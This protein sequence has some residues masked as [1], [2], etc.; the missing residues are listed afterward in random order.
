VAVRG[1]QAARDS[2]QE[3]CDGHKNRIGWKHTTQSR[4]GS[5]L[6]RGKRSQR[7]RSHTPRLSDMFRTDRSPDLFSFN[8]NATISCV[9][10]GGP[11]WLRRP[12]GSS[13]TPAT[14]PSTLTGARQGMRFQTPTAAAM[15]L[16]KTR[17]P[18]GIRVYLRPE[19]ML[20]GARNQGC[21]V[22]RPKTATE[23]PTG[24][25]PDNLPLCR[26]DSMPDPRSQPVGALRLAG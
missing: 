3:R 15:I 10:F 19:K 5:L 18:R 25:A 1:D 4:R 12:D 20:V 24:S 14:S 16:R 26:A 2:P 8:R 11:W 13:R 23:S 9:V 7:R 17:N 21:R 6:A 22:W